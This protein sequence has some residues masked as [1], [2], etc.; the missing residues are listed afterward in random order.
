MN[1]KR[2]VITGGPGTGKTAVIDALEKKGYFCYQEIIRE[3]TLEAKKEGK[4]KIQVVNPLLFVDDPMEFNK[5]ILEGRLQQYKQ[6]S[7]LS[8]AIV[9]FDRGLPDVLAYMDYFA[10]KYGEDFAQV[11]KEHRYDTVF[12][13]PP[14]EEIYVSDNERL[15]T[16]EQA[17]QIHEHLEK[18]YSNYK[19]INV[20]VPKGTIDQRLQFIEE[21]LKLL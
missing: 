8:E 13:L 14:W 10:Q 4:E 21:Y 18:T 6:A 1:P 20:I 15:E 3:M 11:C 12:L 5:K 9:F 17:V 16:Y 7:N 2:I 19:Y